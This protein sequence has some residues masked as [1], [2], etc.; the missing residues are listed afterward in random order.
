MKLSRRHAIAGAAVALAGCSELQ[1][2]VE[3]RADSVRALA[4]HPLAGITTISVI[5]RSNGGHD[6]DAI[7]KEAADYWNEHAEEYAEVDVTFTFDDE[8]PDIELVFLADRAGLEG[9]QEHASREILGCAPLLRP[10]H[11]PERPITVEVVSAGQ[12]YGDVRI[13]AKHELGHTLGL[14]HGDEPAYIMSNDI[15]DRLPE[16]HRR[17]EILDSIENGWNGRNSGTREYNRGIDRWKDSDYAEAASTFEA[18][19]SRYRTAAASVD[20]AIEVET[21]FDGMNRPETVDR[22]SLR[23]G[24]DRAHEW[25]DLAVERSELMAESATARNDGEVQNART[26]QREAD[27]VFERLREVDF[28]APV[29]VARSLGL[30]RERVSVAEK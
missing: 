29:E 2:E 19:A 25:I 22:E 21:G 3:E 26:S 6:V 14:G 15:E 18:A 12:P 24:F 30:V 16:Y 7:A 23:A 9:C 11:R 17:I 13:T 10:G 8:A 20:T 5:D 1:I 27:Q 28:P 4:G